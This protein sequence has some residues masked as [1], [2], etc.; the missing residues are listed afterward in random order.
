MK[1]GLILSGIILLL[2]PGCIYESPLTKDN[3]IP[4]DSA[5]LG[6]WELI[7]EKSTKEEKMMILKYSATEYLIHYPIGDND[8]YFRGYPIKIGDVS[9]VQLE[10]V[11]TDD[12]SLKK[13]DKERFH[14][15]S[16]QLDNDTLTIKTLNTDLVDE[17]LKDTESLKQE[18]LKHQDAQNLFV[19]PGKFRKV[20]KEILQTISPKN[21]L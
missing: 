8:M 1:Y 6:L 21:E 9:C 2:L 18:F 13:D 12:G 17:K 15:A 10:V 19:D 4:I 5:V 3:T 16:Y 11:G 20:Q 7:E 14:V